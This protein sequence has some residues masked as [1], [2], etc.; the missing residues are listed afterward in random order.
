MKSSAMPMRLN[1]FKLLYDLIRRASPLVEADLFQLHRAVQTEIILNIY[2]PIGTWKNQPNGTYYI[3]RNSRQVWCE[4]AR[5]D[6]IP[7]LMA[8][9]L[10]L[11]NHTLTGDPENKKAALAAY[12]RLHLGFARIHPFSDGNGHMA[13]LIANLLVIQSGLP[14]IVVARKRR[15]KYIGLLVA[16]DNSYGTSAIGR[17]LFEE[18]SALKAIQDFFADHWRQILELL[19]NI[20]KVQYRR[21][22]SHHLGFR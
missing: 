11:L 20:W 19:D 9:W 12:T 6:H 4:Y 18:G 5:P 3:D 21:L 1:C 22:F 8:D 2:S 13:R 14:P 16:Y 17:P 15:R 7:A 10:A